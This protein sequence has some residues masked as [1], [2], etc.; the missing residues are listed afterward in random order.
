MNDPSH[1]GMQ[2]IFLVSSLAKHKAVS[3]DAI[4]MNTYYFGACV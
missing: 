2:K 4:V 1:W 3:Q